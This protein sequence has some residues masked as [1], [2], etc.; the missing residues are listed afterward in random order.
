VTHRLGPDSSVPV[1]RDPSAAAH[2][3]AG[4]ADRTAEEPPVFVERGRHRDRDASAR[5]WAS[6]KINSSIDIMKLQIFV[7]YS[8]IYFVENRSIA[9]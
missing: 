3:D 4:P 1:C 9:L 8:V 6:P 2:R 5:A 7:F